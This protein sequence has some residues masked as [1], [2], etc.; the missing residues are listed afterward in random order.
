MEYTYL[1]HEVYTWYDTMRIVPPEESPAQ[2][3][4][5]N[6]TMQ[7]VMVTWIGIALTGLGLVLTAVQKD[8]GRVTT[9]LEAK[10]IL[11]PQKTI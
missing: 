8:M 7:D 3:L 9:E 11:S 4:G 1:S 10:G 2:T 6:P 5:R